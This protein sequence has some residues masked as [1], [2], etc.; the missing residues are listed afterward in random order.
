MSPLVGPYR[1]RGPVV[2]A[3]AWDA[4][5]TRTG[6][7]V[8]LD[9]NGRVT[10]PFACTLADLL[11]L[12]GPDPAWAAGLALGT[13]AALVRG[14]ARGETHGW[15]G[16]ESVVLG[17]QGWT[18]AWLPRNAVSAVDDV[19]TLGSLLSELDDGEL[20]ELGAAFA[21][22]P[23]PSTPDAARLVVAACAAGLA[24]AHHALVSRARHQDR[25][26][27]QRRLAALAARLD[28]AGRPPVVS[29]IVNEDPDG[30]RLTLTS[31]GVIVRATRVH[32]ESPTPDGYVV[33]GPTGLD[34]VAA[35]AVLRSWA[36]GAG[37]PAL[38]PL[39]RW[40]AAAG[41]LRVDR[42]LLSR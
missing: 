19:R 25:S 26:W 38:S 3:A 18:L 20:G 42:R 2:G 23:P 1:V 39:T 10:A 6:E 37:D 41:R 7:R 40:L 8:R 28:L 32:P 31:D 21:E 9:G 16:P 34:P 12:E 35:R 5:D 13:F 11:P 36:T 33:Y 4:W 24:R 30:V 15:I 29:G 27:R 22:D 17:A 14:H